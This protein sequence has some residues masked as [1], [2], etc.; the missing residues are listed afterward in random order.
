[1]SAVLESKFAGIESQPLK[2]FLEAKLVMMSLPLAVSLIDENDG[3]D[4]FLDAGDDGF[5]DDY[6][7]LLVNQEDIADFYADNKTELM[8]FL[9]SYAVAHA[10]KSG[11]DALA[12]LDEVKGFFDVFEIE[13]ALVNP[14]SDC[15]VFIVGQLIQ[16]ASLTLLNQYIDYCA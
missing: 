1:M 16:L 5:S 10:H 2:T 15:H 12:R 7:T 4:Y 6:H 13:D 8:Q 9:D 11:I 3:E 14:K